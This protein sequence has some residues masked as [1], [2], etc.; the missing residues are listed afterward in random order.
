HEAVVIALRNRIELVIVA[1]RALDREAEQAA[2]GR[3]DQIVEVLV[4]AFR[5]VLLAERD[6]RSRAQEAGRDER[7]VAP[8][9]E[10][11]AGEL[12]LEE[13]VVRLVLVERA[14]H[15]VAIAPSV[16]PIVVL[17]EA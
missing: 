15:V 17:L 12:F 7:L 9:L 8:G 4:A 14:N 10:L 11:V 1:A 5:V 3:R 13:L 16:G 6:A 2:A